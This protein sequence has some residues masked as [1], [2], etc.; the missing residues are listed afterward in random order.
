MKKWRHKKGAE[1]EIRGYKY[2]ILIYRRINK[3][4]LSFLLH[5]SI[6]HIYK[7]SIRLLTFFILYVCILFFV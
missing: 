1:L 2:E 5:T 6:F 7:D 4:L 3:K